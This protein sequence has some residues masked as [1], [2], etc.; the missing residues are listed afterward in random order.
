M[1]KRTNI[2]SKLCK[3]SKL[4]DVKKE[5]DTKYR[6]E[7]LE[8]LKDFVYSGTNMELEVIKSD[9][10]YAEADKDEFTSGDPIDVIVTVTRNLSDI[11]FKNE[12]GSAISYALTSVTVNGDGTVTYKCRLN[13]ETE[14]LRTITAT[15][16]DSSGGVYLSKQFSFSISKS[17]NFVS[18]S[19]DKNVALIDE[20]VYMTVVAKERVSSVSIFNE[21]DR[22]IGATCTLKS[23]LDDGTSVYVYRMSIGTAGVDR[24]FYV[25]GYDSDGKEMGTI[26]A[27]PITVTKSVPS[28]L[29]VQ[30]D[31]QSVK[32]NEKLSV[33]VVTNT[34]TDTVDIMSTSGLKMGKVVSKTSFSNGVIDWQY[35]MSVGTAGSRREF[36]VIA[37][38]SN[39]GSNTDDS[40]KLYLEVYA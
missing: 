38:N 7:V 12:N 36:D 26:V 40:E 20:P 16:S 15:A 24:K 28:V 30:S 31:K 27:D 17:S 13:I 37:S 5:Q 2:F 6:M 35:E 23:E 22:K 21:F 39:S 4:L 29:S 11:K 34:C 19:F 18:A 33:N 9:I 14:G 10:T 3:A 32:V 8:E 1:V 25:K